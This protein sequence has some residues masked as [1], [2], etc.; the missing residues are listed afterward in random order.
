MVE[1]REMTQQ[2]K[3]LPA[4]SRAKFGSQHLMT[5]YNHL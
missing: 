4:Y 3:T 2:L 5:A 1:A